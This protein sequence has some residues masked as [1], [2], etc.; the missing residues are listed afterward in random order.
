MPA[1]ENIDPQ[2]AGILK[3]LLSGQDP[4]LENRVSGFFNRMGAKKPSAVTKAMAMKLLQDHGVN[5]GVGNLVQGKSD[6]TGNYDQT[7]FYQDLL[8]L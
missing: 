5:L 1:L 8:G 3:E 6:L 4:N 2:R 7:R